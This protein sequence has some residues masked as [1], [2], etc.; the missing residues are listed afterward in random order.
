[1]VR[2]KSF[3]E[4][5]L[6]LS[7]A[8]LGK[9]IVFIYKWLKK[10]PLFAGVIV[11]RRMQLIM[12]SMFEDRQAVDFSRNYSIQHVHRLCG[13]HATVSSA[14]LSISM[15]KCRFCPGKLRTKRQDHKTAS[16]IVGTLGAFAR[17]S[18]ELHSHSPAPQRGAMKSSLRNRQ[19]GGSDG[20]GGGGGL[21]GS[22]S[23]KNYIPVE[24]F[25]EV[26]IFLL[27]VCASTS[28]CLS[29]CMNVGIDMGMARVSARRVGPISL[30]PP[31]DSI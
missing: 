11:A 19:S 8:C 6:C 9:M 7:R 1:M 22:N 26:S 29:E 15:C 13:T 20:G 31:L 23:H 27:S 4:F 21:G 5:S 30:P 28:R 24:T 3:F 25:A 2:K 17:A 10:V 14:F 12:S 18:G 16:E